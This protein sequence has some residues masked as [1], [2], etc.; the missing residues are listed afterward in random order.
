MKNTYKN[1]AMIIVY[2]T[3]ML[4]FYSCKNETALDCDKGNK[5]ILAQTGEKTSN[6]Y[7]LFVRLG[8]SA[9]GCTGCIV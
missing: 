6:N 7:V 1:L 9:Q 2:V 5:L 8:H 3:M 4:G